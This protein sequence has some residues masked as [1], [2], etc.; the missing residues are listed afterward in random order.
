M[1]LV[2][3]ANRGLCGGYNSSV[4]R[5]AFARY[6]ELGRRRAGD[7]AG[8][9]RQ[10]GHL[11]L[12]L[13]QDRARTNSSPIS[14]TSRVRE[15]ELL[16][17]RYLDAFQSG[18]LDRLDVAYTKFESLSRQYAAVETLLPLA[19]LEGRRRSPTARRPACT[20]SSSLRPRAF[21]TRSCRQVSSCGCSSAFSMRR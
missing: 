14:R 1:L 7:P 12:P 4:L 9:V 8:S 20:T 6:A 16:A 21:S 5:L 10:A 18:R 17:N 2:L 19:G 3:S 11:G 15:V 13:P